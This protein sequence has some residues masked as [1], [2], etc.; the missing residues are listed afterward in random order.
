MGAV[1]MVSSPF[2]RVD[3]RAD[4]GDGVVVY[5]P[6]AR[7]GRIDARTPGPYLAKGRWARQPVYGELIVGAGLHR[8]V[9][10]DGAESLTDLGQ[11][12]LRKGA[13]V[14]IWQGGNTEAPFWKFR[15]RDIFRV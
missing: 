11:R 12:P 4:D 6:V 3:L 8:F 5:L 7:D 1:C 9:W 15:V 13:D 10:G 2:Y 14:R